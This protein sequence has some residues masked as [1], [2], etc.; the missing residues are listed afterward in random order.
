[1]R[2]LAKENK[3]TLTSYIQKPP[4]WFDSKRLN[5]LTRFY[6]KG[7][8][9]DLGAFG[10][11]YTPIVDATLIDWVPE[12]L[13]YKDNTYDYVV[14]GQLLEHLED[15]AKYLKEA[16][17]VLKVGGVL[18][19]SVPLNETEA[20][21]VDSIHLWSFSEQDIIDLIKPYGR[22]EIEILKSQ[23]IPE[24]KYRFPHIIAFVQKQ[25]K[26]VFEIDKNAPNYIIKSEGL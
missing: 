10:T 23:F 3:I 16:M 5:A 8:L 7:K 15:P 21:E 18:A 22:Y 20:G 12:V 25:H 11:A 17:R 4:D 2:R 6:E 14:M 24:Y 9:L 26:L 19:L 13:P 1:M